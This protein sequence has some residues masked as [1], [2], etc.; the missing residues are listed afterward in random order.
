MLYENSIFKIEAER[1]I[2]LEVFQANTF[3]NLLQIWIL[4]FKVLLL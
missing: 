4:H 1:S 2:S 3:W